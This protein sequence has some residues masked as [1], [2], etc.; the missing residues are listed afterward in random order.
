[1]SKKKV[2]LN[3]PRIRVAPVP[4]SS[5]GFA[6]LNSL[7]AQVAVLNP[8]GIIRFTNHAWNQFAQQNGNPSLKAVGPG[9]NYL[10]VCIRAVSDKAPGARAALSGI[11]NVLKGKRNSFSIE[12][13]CDTPTKQRS[14]TMNVAPLEGKKGGAVISH[15]DITRRRRAEMAVEKSDATLQA[16]LDAATQSIVAV[17]EDG[18]FVIVNASTETMFGYTRDELLGRKMDVLVPDYFAQP[19]SRPMGLGLELEGRHKDGTVFPVEI[20]LSTMETTEG[21]LGVAFVVD[22]TQRRLM[23]ALLLQREQEV[24]T[25]LDN[26][27]DVIVRLDREARY[28]Y[29]NAATTRVAGLPREAILGKTPQE[30]GIIPENLSDLWTR[31]A[32]TVFDSGLPQ[33]IEFAYPSPEGQTIWE[34]RVVPE[35]AVNGA[36]QSVL[37]IGRD[38][39]ERR[40]LE[41]ATETHT[42]EIRALAGRLL[43]IEE[44]ERRRISRELHDNLVQQLASL[45]FDVGGLAAEI[46]S[47][48]RL[49]NRLKALQTRVV[50]A[51]EET[52]LI[53]YELHPSV[54]D[55]LGLV[56]SL[57]SLC[58]EFSA[59][60]PNVELAFT[61]DALPAPPPRRVASSVYRVAQ[62]SLQNIAKHASA[63]HASVALTLQKGTVELTVADDGAGFDIEATRGRGGLGL[64]GMEERARLANGKLSIA[65]QPGHGT[66][67]ALEVPLDAGS[68]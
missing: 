37:M 25:L 66:R 4:K 16:L 8:D 44:E 50:K 31:T 55:D 59:R 62:E 51:S 14:F 63:K 38:I 49:L 5:D 60:A 35:F 45:A 20:G 32:Q 11:K 23:D 12:Y 7:V 24:K 36:V 57:R 68:L 29:V 22:I 56:A 13:P 19:R 53:A 3:S 6:I 30:V 17:N 42:A 21:R 34:E 26:S 54:L 58:K 28:T 52:R 9:A 40:L 10:D 64:I 1:M 18:K 43:T 15:M 48:G 41:K 67:I 61:G 2:A 33:V 47:P 65:S 27:P 46:P 39:T